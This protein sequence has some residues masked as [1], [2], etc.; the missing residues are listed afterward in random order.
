VAFFEECCSHLPLIF[1]SSDQC[2]CFSSVLAPLFSGK[3]LLFS[4]LFSV[5]ITELICCDVL[6]CHLATG[7]K[8][9]PKTSRAQFLLDKTREKERKQTNT[10]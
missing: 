10:K 5:F 7:T 9:N 4:T 6:I 3:F 1:R 2:D 8:K